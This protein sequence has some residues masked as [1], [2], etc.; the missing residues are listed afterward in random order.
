MLSSA[1]SSVTRHWSVEALKPSP[2]Q[3]R[4]NAK[5]KG[6]S[7]QKA[8]AFQW[9][10]DTTE[11]V[12]NVVASVSGIEASEIKLDSEMTDLGIDSLMARS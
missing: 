5:A 9:G 3:A 10:R 6:A 4:P 8:K 12:R 2:L 11:E 1:L 7:S